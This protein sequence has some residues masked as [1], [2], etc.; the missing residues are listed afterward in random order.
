MSVLIVTGSRADWRLV[1]PVVVAAG[2]EA[3]LLVTG[4]HLSAR[5]GAT[6]REIESAGHAIAA[7]VPILFDTDSALNV[8]RAT[9][10]CVSGCA[11]AMARINPRWVLV[12][13]DRYESFAAGVAA[14]MMGISL[15]HLGGGETDVSTNQ[16]CNLRN[17]LTRLAQLHFVGHELAA[18]RLRAMGEEAWRIHVVGLPS[19][20]GIAE[21]AADFAALAAAAGLP[22]DVGPRGSGAGRRLVL[23]SF[24]PVTLRAEQAERDLRAML[25]ALG[26]L[27]V[28]HKLIVLSN[29]DAEGDRIDARTRAWA[30]GRADA[31]LVAALPP[32]IY[33][34]ALRDA[35]CYVGNSSSGVTEAPA[36]GC[37]AVIVGERQEGRATAASTVIL[38]RPSAEDIQAAVRAALSSSRG[39]QDDG[40]YRAG[41]AAPRMV[42]LLKRF[43]DDPRLL[44]KRLV[45][46]AAPFGEAAAGCEPSAA[47]RQ[48]PN[49]SA[50]A[51]RG[52]TSFARSGGAR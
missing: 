43:A 31:T 48:A 14:T 44:S 30:K 26:A 34:A 45:E 22:A 20:D 27:D 2:A 6:V 33:L 23:S 49:G 50:D 8:A 29:G 24:L 16:D 35:G 36:L 28:V 51:E 39:V 37:P 19:L 13:G 47:D 42:A 1:E 18:R 9:A 12:A 40:P 15:A 10:L 38:R 32:S 5:H 52:R 17:A 41:G 3:Q 21:Q 4:T 25:A 46:D 11:E 7:R